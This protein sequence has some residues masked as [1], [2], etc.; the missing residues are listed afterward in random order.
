[1]DVFKTIKAMQQYSMEQKRNGK[2]VAVVPTMG[3]LH[4]GHMSLIDLARKNADV[5][6]VTV[7][8]NPTQFG[9]NED[10][11]QY[12]RDFE[13]DRR[14]CEEHGVQAIFAPEPKEMYPADCSTWVTEEKLSRGLCAKT[15]PTHFRGVA[16]VVT[17]LFHAVLPDVAVFGQKDAQQA[18]ILGRMIRDLNFPIRMIV[19]PIVREADGLALSSRNKYLSAEDRSRAPAISHSLAAAQARMASFPDTDPAELRERIVAEIT[20]SGGR[21]DYVE[22]LDAAT[23]ESPEVKTTRLII[24]VAVYYGATRLID[25]VLIDMVGKQ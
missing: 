18:L 19:G 3:F 14:L 11:A 8:V 12:P 4:D 10:F 9:P 7:F 15:R 1:M 2:T 22:V 13:H 6:V 20:G 5:V 16:T 23:L 24:A 25:N 17:K 21:I